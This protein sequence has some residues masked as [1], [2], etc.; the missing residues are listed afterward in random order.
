MF[1]ACCN[2]HLDVAKWLVTV[3]AAADIRTTD[4]T[5]QV[6]MHAVCYEGHLD[7]ANWLF[8]GGA[9]A[10]IRA[11]DD[12][13]WTPMFV[14][15]QRGH[16][17]TAQWLLAVG[18]PEDVRAKDVN[19]DS[20]MI[21]DATNPHD[22]HDIVDWLILHG[23]ANGDDG[24]VDPELVNVELVE[25]HET[26]TTITPHPRAALQLLVD[27]QA[28]FAYVVLPAVRFGAPVPGDD[29]D[30]GDD[31]DE[32]SGGKKKRRAG[33]KPSDKCHL[34]LLRGHEET[35]L[36]LIAT[37]V[38]VLRGRQLRNAREVLVVMKR[39]DIMKAASAV[40]CPRQ[41]MAC[42]RRAAAERASAEPSDDE[43]AED[44]DEDDDEA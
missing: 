1:A 18:T 36:S 21:R 38:G 20:L 5:G 42:E 40:S 6:P 22:Y 11:K 33:G 15:C 13:D 9:A 26:T 39:A 2:G 31:D 30:D 37:F 12:E 27:G 14:A 25:R 16:L 4:D 7:M 43:A 17:K 34:P 35:L 8:A 28:A 29:N 23:A 32:G 41:S 44:D 19:G 10:D 3:G 24:H